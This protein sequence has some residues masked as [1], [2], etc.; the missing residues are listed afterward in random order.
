[1]T[2]P[3]ESPRAA[4]PSVHLAQLSVV[5]V[6]NQVDPSI[7]NPDFLRHNQI[8][9]PDAQ[10][11][12]PSVSTPQLSQV[13]FQDGVTVKANQN[14]VIFEEA[15]DPLQPD[16]VRSPSMAIRFVTLFPNIFY[17]AIG[18]NPIAV[19]FLDGAVDER[20]AIENALVDKGQWLNL[21]GQS[22]KLGLR[23]VYRLQNKTVFLEI[24]D[25]EASEADAR[26]PSVVAFRSNIHRDID[27]PDQVARNQRLLSVLAKW[28]DDL[29]DFEKLI[30]QF[31]SRSTTQ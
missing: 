29:K 18:I 7:L 30:G 16:C 20:V 5:L 2:D 10:V 19:P 4:G 31:L 8:V 26:P 1:M 14:Q 6:V 3:P 12:A 22:P 21:C 24:H 9:D 25:S 17:K 28:E 23:T 13:T 27:E 11:S 15:G